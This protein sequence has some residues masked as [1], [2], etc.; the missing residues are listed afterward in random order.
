MTDIYGERLQ[1]L[2]GTVRNPNG[3]VAS[4]GQVHARALQVTQLIL[5]G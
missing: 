2:E 5:F 1:Y 4:N 3:I